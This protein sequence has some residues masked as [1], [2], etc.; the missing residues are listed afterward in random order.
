VPSPTKISYAN[1]GPDEA[2]TAV[3]TSTIIVIPVYEGVV[4]ETPVVVDT[5]ISIGSPIVSWDWYFTRMKQFGS[6]YVGHL[7][8]QSPVW[9]QLFTNVLGAGA[10]FRVD[11]KV[12]TASGLSCPQF[13]T[14]WAPQIHLAPIVYP[15]TLSH[16]IPDLLVFVKATINSYTAANDGI[17]PTPE[18]HSA[19]IGSKTSPGLNA[20]GP[21]SAF[22][23][24][25]RLTHASSIIYEYTKIGQDIIGS[26]TAD[27]APGFGDPWPATI[28]IS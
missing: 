8:G 13:F 1:A 25:L 10:A 16:D 15:A 14:T 28:T 3:P 18:W 12:V 5:T 19:T 17:N 7:V 26:F 11:L 4:N 27:I 24:R 2:D 6:F 20:N 21:D 23:W 9:P 22:S